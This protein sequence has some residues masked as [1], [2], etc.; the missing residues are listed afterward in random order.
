MVENIL[1]VFKTFLAEI[2]VNESMVVV[3]QSLQIAA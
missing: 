2:H 3:F 1:E